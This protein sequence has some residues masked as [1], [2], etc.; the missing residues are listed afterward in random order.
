MAFFTPYLLPKPNKNGVAISV[1]GTQKKHRG[2]YANLTKGDQAEIDYLASIKNHNQLTI[3]GSSE[4]SDSPFCPFH[5]LPDSV[6][7]P[8]IGIGH[9]YHQHFSILCELLAADEYIKNAKIAIVISLGWFDTKG[10]N[11]EAFI[12]FVRPNFLKKIIQDPNINIEYKKHIGAYIDS[13][14]KE[15]DGISNEMELF[16][17]VYLLNND[18][19][20]LKAKGKLRKHFK[21]DIPYNVNYSIQTTDIEPK[22]LTGNLANLSIKVQ[23][24]F[25]SKISTNN[26]YVY[27]AYYTEY[28]L[29]KNGNQKNGYTPTINLKNNNEFNDFLMV[30]KYLKSKHADVSMIIQPLNPYYYSN[31]ENYDDLVKKIT[32]VLNDN[33]I[34]LLNMH[35]T[36]KA[37]YESGTLKDV[38]H[39]GDYGWMK[40]NSF[41]LDQYHEKKIN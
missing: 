22:K 27:D 26:I 6:G 34:P 28:L 21:T 8:T 16:R 33:Q 11:T 32:R 31:L 30:V 10:T 29:E 19:Y 7:F 40:V 25:L 23:E 38:M 36:D 15:V 39:F 4:F 24:D 14:A 20:W 35:I 18:N 5:F 37:Q 41:L 1:K 12:E 3:F 9:A 2:T 17:D 13:H